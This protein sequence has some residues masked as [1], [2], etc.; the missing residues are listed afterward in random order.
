MPVRYE[1]E[2]APRP[3]AASTGPAR[4][5]AEPRGPRGPRD[6]GKAAR[7]VFGVLIGVLLVATVV[8]ALS[9]RGERDREQTP[10]EDVATS[11]PPVVELPYGEAAVGAGATTVVAGI[12][13]GYPRTTD[14]AVSAA[15]TY[16][17]AAGT[18]LFVTPEKRTQIAE[19]IYTPAA[20]ENGVLTD[21]VA[22][23]VQDELNVTPDGLGLRADGTIDASR[24][25]F[26]ECLYQY[27]AYRVDDVDAS[28]DPSEVVV[29]T[30]APCLNGVG[31]A[32]DGS[33]VQVRWSEATTTM[34]WSGTDWQ[35]AETTYPTH[36]P[37][38]PDQP[39]A[40]NVSLTE[41]ARL[42]GDGWVV[43]ADATDTFDP[44]IGI[45]EL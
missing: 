28:T 35:I 37:P 30:W 8:G 22:A 21:E 36:T 44:T 41:R 26:A 25:A 14:G 3:T 19:T 4:A 39:R 23:A 6:R 42:L 38:A 18:A 15:L 10:A 12:P 7:W 43:P 5:A 45:G 13:S 31:S 16:A 11:A 40:V 33:A 34:R 24:R 2:T 20:R 1:D 9:V 29:T 27:G 17:N 32:D